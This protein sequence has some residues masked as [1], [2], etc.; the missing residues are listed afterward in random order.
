MGV[1]DYEVVRIQV[2]PNEWIKGHFTPEREAMPCS[3]QWGVHGWS[4]ADMDVQACNRGRGRPSRVVELVTQDR[5]ANLPLPPARTKSPG[6]SAR[7]ISCLQ[8]VRPGSA[9]SEESRL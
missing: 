7:D 5:P 9:L 6:R 8:C 4:F 1:R 3:E 2:W